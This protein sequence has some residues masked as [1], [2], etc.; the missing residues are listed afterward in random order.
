MVSEEELLT[1]LLEGGIKFCRVLAGTMDASRLQAFLRGFVGLCRVEEFT[2]EYFVLG[3]VDAAGVLRF[4]I[5]CVFAVQRART[6]E[7]SFRFAF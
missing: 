3:V 2:L 1:S 6:L 5:V 7:P 4:K